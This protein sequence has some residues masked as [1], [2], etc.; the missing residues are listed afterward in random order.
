MSSFVYLEKLLCAL[1]SELRAYVAVS[2]RET[3][4][5]R[6]LSPLSPKPK[7]LPRVSANTADTN[8]KVAMLENHIELLADRLKKIQD[9]GSAAEIKARYEQE[10]TQLLSTIAD[11]KKETAGR[12]RTI[13]VLQNQL[14]QTNDQ[15]AALQA[16]LEA[17]QTFQRQVQALLVSTTTHKELLSETCLSLENRLAMLIEDFYRFADLLEERLL[18]KEQLAALTSKHAKLELD[19]AA[20]NIGLSGDSTPLVQL[21]DPIF[22]I[23]HPQPWTHSDHK[24]PHSHVPRP[25]YATFI[26]KEIPSSKVDLVE[27]PYAQWLEVT[28]RGILDSK[29]AEHVLSGLDLMRVRRSFPEFV[30]AWMG[31]YEV[32]ERKREVATL[33]WSVR[34]EVDARRYQLLLALATEKAKKAWEI[35][36]FREFLMENMD[37]DQLSF[38]LHC[39]HLLFRGPQLQSNEGKYAVVHYVPLTH[40]NSL[41]DTLMSKL[42]HTDRSIVKSL[43]LDKAR[44]KSGVLHIDASYVL[45][46]FLMYYERE[47]SNKCRQIEEL[48]QQAPKE[49][50]PDQGLFLSFF[51]FRQILLNLNSDFTDLDLVYLYRLTWDQT[52]LLTPA[53]LFSALSR[54]GALSL[55]LRLGGLWPLP[56]LN[57]YNDLDVGVNPLND[58]YANVVSDWK[59]MS[60]RLDLLKDS[61]TRMGLL[62]L[63]GTIAKCELVLR[64]KGQVK[65]EETGGRHL[66]EMYARLWATLSQAGVVQLEVLGIEWRQ[67]DEHRYSDY[68]SSAC[69]DLKQSCLSFH[70]ASHHLKV[71]L[72]TLKFAVNQIQRIWLI[73]HPRKP[74]KRHTRAN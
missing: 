5:P 3:P 27:T 37:L 69:S 33:N 60:K 11:L 34:E 68:L 40:A 21:D 35:W 31:M 7:A 73:L 9:E 18:L 49:E 6:A 44:S 51:A 32:G 10:K 13:A 28:V 55:C 24:P 46:V 8:L 23:V 42:P 38:F 72:F 62:G 15:L 74:T 45:R 71:S 16:T 39:R 22:R 64:R 70:A 29:Y 56:V 54:S 43:L 25:T 14:G 19:I 30:Y 66:G 36:T 47:R 26:S 61:V 58:I 57:A 2:A 59:L 4:L 63:A 20:G 1:V 52:G 17:Q 53:S 67:R 41:I 50:L 48:F 12:D 65:M